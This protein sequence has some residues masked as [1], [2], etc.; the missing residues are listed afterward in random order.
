MYTERSV[1]ALFQWPLNP[2]GCCG[3]NVVDPPGHVWA[4][5]L[6]WGNGVK[7]KQV[8][9]LENRA[10]K[11]GVGNFGSEFKF[12]FILPWLMTTCIGMPGPA[13]LLLCAV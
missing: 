2:L 11:V 1:L 8:L 12:Q 13:C 4:P 7:F 5:E 6:P 10:G 9:G 3:C